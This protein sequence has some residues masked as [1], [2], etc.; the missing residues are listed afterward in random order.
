MYL[1]INRLYNDKYVGERWAEFPCVL[2][3]VISL[4]HNSK[5]PQMCY[6]VIVD[7]IS[8]QFVNVSN[9]LQLLLW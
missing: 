3:E 2:L 5:S 9:R 8:P 6:T 1:I 7:D 4:K